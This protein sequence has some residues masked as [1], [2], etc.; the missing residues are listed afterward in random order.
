MGSSRGGEPDEYPQHRVYLSSFYLDKFEVT[1]EQYEKFRSETGHQPPQFWDD[2]RFNKPNQP[3][4]GVSFHDAVTYCQWA[5]KR[6][7]T[8]AEWEKAARGTEGQIYPWGN[9]FDW[10]KGNFSDKG[11]FDG[12]LDGFAFTAPVGSFPETVSPYGVQDMAGNVWEW[13]ADWYHKDYYQISPPINPKGPDTGIARVLR[14][15][16]F[17]SALYLRCSARYYLEE[18]SKYFYAGFRCASDIY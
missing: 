12:H 6:L 15:G 7:P 8:E 18:N 1:N 16:S 11:Q 13:C 17:F 5:G 10:T 2:P 4:V 9:D 14:G 3:V